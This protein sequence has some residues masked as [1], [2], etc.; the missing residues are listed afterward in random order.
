MF[1]ISS[2]PAAIASAVPDAACR[3]V[4]VPRTREELEFCPAFGLC[5][6]NDRPQLELA[7]KTRQHTRSL[8]RDW[9]TLHES[10][11][12]RRRGAAL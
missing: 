2:K 6:V 3:L 1:I 7:R 11:G 9:L 12:G 10:A 5:N 8:G 4:G